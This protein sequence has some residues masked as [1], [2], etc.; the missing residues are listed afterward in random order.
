[1]RFTW[2]AKQN[3]HYH[4]SNLRNNMFPMRH[5]KKEKRLKAMMKSLTTVLKAMTKSPTTSQITACKR[6][7]Q[8]SEDFSGQWTWVYPLWLIP[9]PTLLCYLLWPSLRFSKTSAVNVTK[10]FRISDASHSKLILPVHCAHRICLC[11]QIWTTKPD[12]D[13]SGHSATCTGKV[14]LNAS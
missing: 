1:M 13:V 5:K 12:M 6:F 4:K 8:P 14:T 7:Q 11:V 10:D 2:S 9:L 3:D